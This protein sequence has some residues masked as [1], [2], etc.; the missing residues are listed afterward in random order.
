[1]AFVTWPCGP[2]WD[3]TGLQRW[4]ETDV[5]SGWDKGAL[6]QGA[7]VLRGLWLGDAFCFVDPDLI[8]DLWGFGACVQG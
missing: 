2:S 5:G 8:G 7:S 4:N 1:M 6:T 3:V